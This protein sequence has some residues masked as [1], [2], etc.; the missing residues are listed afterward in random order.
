M[1]SKNLVP[2]ISAM[3]T[4]FN[5]GIVSMLFALAYFFQLIDQ[6]FGLGSGANLYNFVANTF[7]LYNLI[8]PTFFE[9]IIGIFFIEYVII[10]SYMSAGIKYGFDKTMTSYYIGRNLLFGTIFYVIFS[11][12]GILIVYTVFGPYLPINIQL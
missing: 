10:T 7:N 1:T 9:A 3:V 11:I 5:N 6:S 8:P 4:V 12:I 2:L